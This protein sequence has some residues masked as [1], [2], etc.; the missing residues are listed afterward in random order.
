MSDT[1][2]T[3]ENVTVKRGRVVPAVRGARR[4][5]CV[6][7]AL[8]VLLLAVA[9][10]A[11]ANHVQVTNAEI[12]SDGAVQFDISWENSWRESWT[13]AGGGSAVEN[14]D[15]AWV[16][17]KYRKAGETAYSHATLSTNAAHHSAPAG[18]ALDVGRTAGRTPGEGVGV[19]IYRDTTGNPGSNNWSGV[20]LKWEYA[21]DGVSTGSDVEIQ[22]HAIEMVYVPE[23]AFKVGTGGAEV[24]SF[25]DGSWSSGNTIPF[26]IDED[27][28]GPVVEGTNA[29]RIGN[30]DGQLWGT[31]TNLNNNATIGPAGA[32]HDNYPTGY[33]AFYCMKYEITQGQYAAFLNST[34]DSA[35]YH[36]IAESYR[37]ALTGAIGS[38]TTVR[39]Y[40]AC[41]F[42]SWADAAAYKA[43]AGLRPMTE[44]EFEKA[45]RGPAEPVSG[46]FAWGSASITQATGIADEG[47]ADERASNSAANAVWNN[48]GTGGPLRTG[49]FA[50]SVSGRTAAG[51]SYW[52]IM[53]LSGNL[54]TRAV[55]VAA[56]SGDFTGG[57]QFQG[58]HGS[59]TTAL[60]ADWP[61]S[62]AVGAGFR[63]GNWNLASGYA[64]VS[65]RHAAAYVNSDRNHNFGSR[66]VRAAPSGVGD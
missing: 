9:P 23:G 15:A 32:L 30:V 11:Q 51:A 21:L 41:N 31:T 6:A 58:T 59:G 42:L 53:E 44:L 22:V 7:A 55:G 39:P 17:V 12:A 25:T 5:A 40:V 19:F 46:E 64:R 45:C 43:W 3:R 50:T 14:W 62:A 47:A 4:A 20:K 16:F 49:V 2:L 61:Q 66:A 60:P 28:S 29:R 33:S 34:L 1:K 54:W 24:G 48:S 56:N 13:P 37:Y 35:R 8:A 36:N 63:G 52:G 57:R 10:P 38:I 65:H 18:A 27:W 26:L